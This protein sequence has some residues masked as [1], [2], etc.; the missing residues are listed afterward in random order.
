MEFI[1][2]PTPGGS[3][4][5]GAR[6]T[7]IFD[8]FVKKNPNVPWK[9]TP[10][11]PESNKQRRFFEGAVVP[12]IAYYQEGLDHRN[13]E[14]CQRVREW[15]KLEFNGEFL[16]LGGTITTVSTTHKVAKS[17]KGRDALQPFLERVME[18][19]IENYAP[20]VEALDVENFKHWHDVV[21]PYGGPDNYIDYL[22]SLNLLKR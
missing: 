21:F 3:L 19:L 9:L 20:P 1:A 5:L 18:W 11:L 6:N 15:L 14:D 16:T 13:S 8:D 12:L 2:R 10:V 22:T 7:A 17:T 4:N